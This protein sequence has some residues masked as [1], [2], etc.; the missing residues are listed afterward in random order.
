MPLFALES[1]DLNENVDAVEWE[2]EQLTAVAAVLVD[3]Q[4]G[5]IIFQRNIHKSMPPASMLKVATL[6]FAYEELAKKNIPLDTVHIIKKGEDAFSQPRDSSLMYLYVG[7]KVSIFELMQG[8]A[9][10]SGN[11]ASYALA[12]VVSGDVTSF[13]R[14]LNAYSKRRKWDS[15]VFV[16]PSGYDDDNVIS[17]FDYIW[18]AREYILNHPEALRDLHSVASFTYPKPRNAYTGGRIVRHKKNTNV[19]LGTGNIDGLKTGYTELAGF[20]FS[21]TAK[22]N[23]TRFLAVV[24]GVRGDSFYDYWGGIERRAEEASA[25]LE[26]GFAHYHTYHH[27]VQSDFDLTLW[28]A[29]KSTVKVYQKSD[30]YHT[31][32]NSINDAEVKTTV[33]LPSYLAGGIDKDQL[34]GYIRYQLNGK[35][36][37]RSHLY[38]REKVAKTNWLISLFISLKSRFE[39]SVNIEN[40][41]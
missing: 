10:A 24:L 22:R 25:L 15:F 9:I 32:K 17:A 19:L 16:D 26:Y 20:N 7:D 39:P 12:N 13:L 3:I 41:L 1:V 14:Q 33:V 11:D 31:L 34:V 21:L 29:Q 4:T 35:E 27:K 28:G 8:V 30:F 2:P 18:L 36:I 23:G 38:T 5:E 6:N 40:S 37:G